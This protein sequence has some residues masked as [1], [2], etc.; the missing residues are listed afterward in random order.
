MGNNA[1]RFGC[2]ESNWSCNANTGVDTLS[3]KIKTWDQLEV[4]TGIDTK[5]LRVA[6]PGLQSE[7][8]DDFVTKFYQQYGVCQEQ[9]NIPFNWVSLG[10]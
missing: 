5:N 8:W 4:M 10:D 1:Y 7:M 3:S 2:A 6:G 9:P